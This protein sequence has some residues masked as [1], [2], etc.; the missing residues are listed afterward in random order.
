MGSGIKVGVTGDLGKLKKLTTELKA[1]VLSKF[2]NQSVGRLSSQVQQSSSDEEDPY[3]KAWQPAAG[4]NSDKGKLLRKTGKML[5]VSKFASYNAISLRSAPRY[6]FFH[7]HGATLRGR[8]RRLALSGPLEEQR[9][10]GPLPEFVIATKG[11]NKGKEV[12]P[13]RRTF[14]KKRQKS[15]KISGTGKLRGKLPARPFLPWSV[16]PGKWEEIMRAE[17]DSVMKSNLRTG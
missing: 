17:F 13:R 2:A 7:S 12:R 15:A 3:G 4:G 9:F 6:S 10:I 8:K 14:R 5:S 11:K 16:L 1:P